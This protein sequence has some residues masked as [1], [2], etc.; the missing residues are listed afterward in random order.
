MKRVEGSGAQ[1]ASGN[2]AA[3]DSRHPAAR[4]SRAS[5]VQICSRQIC[6]LDT[7]VLCLSWHKPFGRASHDQV[8]PGKLV[9]GRAQIRQERI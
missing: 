7:A 8:F 4:A 5:G 1:D 2:R 3:A 6:L 9:F